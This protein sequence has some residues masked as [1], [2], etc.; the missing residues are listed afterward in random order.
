MASHYSWHASYTHSGDAC[1]KKPLFYFQIVVE[2]II[3]ESAPIEIPEPTVTSP[4]ATGP[5]SMF[6][7]SAGATKPNKLN[8]KE[9]ELTKKGLSA[10]VYLAHKVCCKTAQCTVIASDRESMNQHCMIVSNCASGSAENYH[11]VICYK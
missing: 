6:S 8:E 5:T 1:T 10:F 3:I 4:P 11:L 9:K 7:F 2:E